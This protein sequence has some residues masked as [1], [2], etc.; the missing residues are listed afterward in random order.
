[1]TKLI[2]SD[3]DGTLLHN[4][5]QEISPRAIRLIRELSRRG[6]RFVAAS[7][8]QY[9]N[10]RLLFDEIKDEISYIA[11]NGSLCIHNG[12]VISKG[13][14]PD[15]L[16]YDIMRDIKNRSGFELLVSR[17]DTCLIEGN[18][19]AFVNHITN[20]MKNTTTVVHDL[21]A[22]KGPFLKIAIADMGGNGL[23]KCLDELRQKYVPAINVVTSGNMWI[24]F[25]IPG[26]NKG[27][28]LCALMDEL[29]I[30]ADECIAFGDQYNDVE[31]LEAAG[32]SFAMANA[33][34]GISRHASFVTDSV[35]DVLEDLLK[36]L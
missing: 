8:R 7:G 20:V 25:V 6:V 23:E 27:T 2:A 26:Y 10:E 28:A 35:E 31:M 30:S 33:A 12:K 9:A 32:K 1:M 36:N 24:D 16:S 22:E 21:L 15:S 5:A 17:E 4:G 13:I 11:E 3:L 14:I 19:P 18:N 29:G 34:P